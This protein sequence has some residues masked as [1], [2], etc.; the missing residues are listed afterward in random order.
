M[1]LSS[2]S[3]V[4]WRRGTA[5]LDYKYRTLID[6]IP[7]ISG[8]AGAFMSKNRTASAANR[9]YPTLLWDMQGRRSRF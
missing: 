9:Q 3:C 8:V 2:A 1:Y 6:V 5:R 7:A 4:I